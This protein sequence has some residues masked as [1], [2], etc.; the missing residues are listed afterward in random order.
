MLVVMT[1]LSLSVHQETQFISAHVGESISLRCLP[2]YGVVSWFHW[3]KVFPGQRPKRILTFYKFTS[4]LEFFDEFADDPRFSLDTEGITFHL[5][6]GDVN[7][8]DSATYYCANSF[9]ERVQFAEGTT[10]SVVGSGI[11]IPAVV[12]QMVS[13]SIQT[14]VTASLNC[15]VHTGSCEGENCFYWFQNPGERHQGLIYTKKERR[16]Q[17]KKEGKTQTCYDN[18]STQNLTLHHAGNRYCAVLSCGHILFKNRI[19]LDF[20]S[21][22]LPDNHYKRNTYYPDFVKCVEDTVDAV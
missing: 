21:K 11:N 9:V 5:K 6:I 8:F 13:K 7:F 15:T 14:K 4:K 3:Y 12:Q 22:S 1:D 17:H 18:L 19:E 20:E 2:V 10:V 16:K